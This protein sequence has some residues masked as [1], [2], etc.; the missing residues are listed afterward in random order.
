MWTQTCG[1]SISATTAASRYGSPMAKR[2]GRSKPWNTSTSASSSSE[3]RHSQNGRNSE[4]RS[5][6]A[7]ADQ[8]GSRSSTARMRVTSS[9]RGTSAG[10][11]DHAV[12]PEDLDRSIDGQ[13][14][15]A[16]TVAA[17]HRCRLEQRVDHGFFSRLD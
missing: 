1:A 11:R 10:G 6:S 7:Y 13:R 15:D 2:I 5:P 3:A 4:L 17:D 9:M 12:L 16:D 8:A 14:L